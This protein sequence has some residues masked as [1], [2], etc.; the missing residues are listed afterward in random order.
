[1]RVG[2]KAGPRESLRRVATVGYMRRNGKFTRAIR[3]AGVLEWYKK[4]HRDVGMVR[5]CVVLLL[6]G[7]NGVTHTNVCRFN[8]YS[9]R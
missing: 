6:P 8:F 9:T 1:M 4:N 7:N 3:F 2:L 5:V